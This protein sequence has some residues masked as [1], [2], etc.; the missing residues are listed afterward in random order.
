[1]LEREVVAIQT[2]IYPEGALP[3]GVIATEANLVLLSSRFQFR[4]Q[5]VQASDQGATTAI[6]LSAGEFRFGDLTLAVDWVTIE[7]R[8]LR[9]ALHGSSQAADSF[10]LAVANSICELAPNALPLPEPIVRSDETVWIG[11]L[12]IEPT[13]LISPVLA[14]VASQL[15][16]DAA[17]LYKTGVVHQLQNLSFRLTFAPLE[18]LP[19]AVHIAPKEFRLEPRANTAPQERLWFSQSPLRTD[20]H[21][22]LLESIEHELWASPIRALSEAIDDKNAPIA[23][24]AI[25]LYNRA[26][27]HNIEGNVAA[28]IQDYDSVLESDGAPVEIKA[29]ALV[30]RAVLQSRQAPDRALVDYSAVIE[31]T[32]AP[33]LQ[34]AK[35]LVNR[36]TL[37]GETGD[38]QRA[39]QDLTR[40]I[41]TPDAPRPIV[42]AA[43]FNRGLSFKKRGAAARAIKDFRSVLANPE[44][45]SELHARAQLGL[46]EILGLRGQRAEELAANEAVLRDPDVPTALRLEAL[47]NRAVIYAEQGKVDLALSDLGEAVSMPGSGGE[48]LAAAFFN[49]GL[50]FQRQQ[51]VDAAVSDYSAAI[52]ISGA[53][54]ETKAAALLNRGVLYSSLGRNAEALE[55]YRQSV[56]TKGAAEVT[57]AALQNIGRRL[58]EGG[59][60]EGAA[61]T[62][63]DLLEMQGVPAT[64]RALALADRAW[65]AYASKGDAAALARDSRA[66]L[67]ANPKLTVARFNLALGLLLM[68]KSSEARKQ[69]RRAASECENATQIREWGLV[70][71]EKAMAMGSVTG[72]AQIV[73]MLRSRET[74]LAR[75]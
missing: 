51:R 27:A 25:A 61:R 40:L 72:A 44:A 29:M 49:R 10:Y 45:G 68:G 37:Q 43:L 47:T 62:W 54:K 6:S 34:R 4:G 41:N 35:A 69:Y 33:P 13:R 55:D 39:M 20:A 64:T 32:D 73:T 5:S 30:N 60:H 24:R 9:L 42:A 52:N 36:A 3:I 26:I 7:P 16:N 14:A 12:E 8:R 2:R 21:R 48:T 19:P 22:R 23:S 15:T 56:A 66:A 71:L 53:S 1:M 18:T 63:H 57:A 65:S 46:G 38:L 67:A 11:R 28:A 31:M 50:L 58:L 74:E 59:D 75:V 70:D 17:V